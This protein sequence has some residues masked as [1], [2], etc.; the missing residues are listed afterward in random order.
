MKLA[1]GNNIIQLSDTSRIPSVNAMAF[2]QGERPTFD[3]V[4]KNI[5]VIKQAKINDVKAEI[6]EIISRNQ[7]RIVPIIFLTGNFGTGKS[8]FAYR[9]LDSFLKDD[10]VE[11][12]AFEFQDISQIRSQDIGELFSLTQA[13]VI[14]ITYSE[15]EVDSAFKELMEFRNKVSVEQFS[16]FN[17]YFL[18]SIRENILIRFLKNYKYKNT[19]E[20]NVDSKINTSEANDLVNKLGD[21]E[22][23]RFRDAIEKRRLVNRISEEFEGDTFISLITLITN[24]N[25]EEFILSAFYQLTKTA[26]EAFLFTS[27][28]YQY[29]I[30]MPSG[31]LMRLVSRDWAQF[32]ADVLKYDSKGILIQEYVE[33]STT[34]DLFFRTRHAIISQHLIHRLIKTEDLLF[35]RVKKI[36]ESL[37]ESD[38]NA[39]LFVDFIKAVRNEKA[40]S[41]EKI[42]RIFDIADKIFEINPHFTLYYAINL[43][44][45]KTI[46]AIKKGI[47][48]IRYSEASLDYRSNKLIHRRGALHYE[49]AKIYHGQG[50]YPN[51]I[52]NID[53]ARELFE[54]KRLDDPGSSYSYIDYINME[55]W[56]L[57]KLNLEQSDLLLLHIKIQELFDWA[58]HAVSENLERIHKLKYIYIKH[59]DSVVS[60]SNTSLIDYLDE[61]YQSIDTRPYS[62]IL[63]YNYF[64]EKDRTAEANTLIPELETLDYNDEV[65]KLLFKYYGRNLY[66]LSNRSKYFKV[67]KKGYDFRKNEPL[68]Y[69]FYSYVAE[70]YNRNF[71]FADDHLQSIHDFDTHFNPDL[72]EVWRDEDGSDSLFTGIIYNT[73]IG[74]TNLK[75]SYIQLKCRLMKESYLKFKPQPTEQFKVKLHFFLKGIRAELIEKL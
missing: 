74:F 64:Q 70:S 63:K 52:V 14:F 18:V 34:P 59:V 3:V 58:L 12:V 25:F 43:Q 35:E 29:K 55:L 73:Q 1:L 21:L 51:T 56:V 31:L 49:L 22:L 67:V 68:R 23:V 72:H 42:N 47:E 39:F 15:V 60:P 33:N 8:T 40:L 20:I 17:I 75:I 13:K 38:F 54:I 48:K 36:V 57:D 41:E 28:L 46:F 45:R 32:D 11:C 69:F 5:D 71:N 44:V 24:N 30:L 10:A 66:L 4:R 7:E 37:I 26:K 6:K 53:E 19:I 50:N 61:L 16:M 27:I 62:L 65:L 9:L 2:Y